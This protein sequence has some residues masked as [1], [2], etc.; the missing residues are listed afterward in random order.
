MLTYEDVTSIDS[1]G[2][3]TAQKDIHVGAGVSAVGVGTFG[4]LDIGGDIDVDGHTNLDNGNVSG[5][6]TFNSGAALHMNGGQI[7][8]KDRPDGN[9]NNLF[10]GTGGRAVIIHDGTNFSQVNNTGHFFLG[11][12]VGNKDLMLYAQASGN[13]LLQQ[14]TG[15]RYVKGVGSDASVQLFFNNNLRLNTTN[16]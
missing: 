14:N 2:I 6:V 3:I 9:S 5:I 15:V 10:F 16:W 12:G 11:Q 13:V 4:S 8:L 1:V 7:L